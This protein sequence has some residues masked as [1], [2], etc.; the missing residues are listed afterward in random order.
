M[1]QLAAKPPNAGASHTGALYSSSSVGPME[2]VIANNAHHSAIMPTM[3][4]IDGQSRTDQYASAS[5]I[6]N[7]QGTSIIS[8]SVGNCVA[9]R[10]GAITV[11]ALSR[12]TVR[13]IASHKP[14]STHASP[15]PMRH[16]AIAIS[17]C[18][19]RRLR[20]YSAT[21]NSVSRMPPGIR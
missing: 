4:H 14:R 16:A 8:Q 11:S 9:H 19:P 21:A 7:A 18:V 3:A 15:R 17:M 10:T 1:T 6:D 20:R 12:S 13:A 5:T 2:N